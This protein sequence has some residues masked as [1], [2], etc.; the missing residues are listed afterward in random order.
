MDGVEREE[1]LITD[2]IQGLR[3]G[4]FS[5]LEPRL[6][7]SDAGESQFVQWHREGRFQ[8]DPVAVAEALSC[9]CFLGLV[10]TAE[11][12]LLQG[13]DPAAGNATGMDALHWAVNRGQ[14]ETTRLLLRRNPP[15]EARNAHGTTVLGTAVWSAIH[16]PK[17]AHR[18]IIRELLAAG[19]L[20]SNVDFPSGD[21]GI[22]ELLSG[23]D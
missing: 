8:H 5:R 21:T 6:R 9:A 15:L 17:P 14:V 7:S 18:Q 4:D 22:D 2:T 12:L 20:V 19:A 11:Y 3:N 1:R 10:D 23:Q 16:E 13:L